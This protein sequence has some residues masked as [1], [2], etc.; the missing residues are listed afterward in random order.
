MLL[1]KEVL[2]EMEAQWKGKL[3]RKALGELLLMTSPKVEL[4]CEVEV[5]PQAEAL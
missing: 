4:L 3:P 1:W 5:L 2:C